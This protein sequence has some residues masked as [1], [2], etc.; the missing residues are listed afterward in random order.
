MINSTI[1]STRLQGASLLLAWLWCGVF[2]SGVFQLTHSQII[3]LLV[4]AVVAIM[5]GSIFKERYTEEIQSTLM[6][7]FCCLLSLGTLLVYLHNGSNPLASSEIAISL[8]MGIMG[9]CC[10]SAVFGWLT[11]YARFKMDVVTLS[12]LLN[13]FTSACIY[14]LLRCIKDE[15]LIVALVIL[16][17]VSAVFHY[18]V[19]LNH[20]APNEINDKTRSLSNISF[21]FRKAFPNA[22]LLAAVFFSSGFF[23]RIA[24]NS[25]STE[26]I[27]APLGIIIVAITSLIFL[28]FLFS[29]KVGMLIIQYTSLVL[30]LC[31]EGL[32]MFQIEG[33]AFA[34]SMLFGALL[35]LI[36]FLAVAFSVDIAN[37]FGMRLEKVCGFFMGLSML[38]L[39]L[40]EILSGMVSAYITGSALSSIAAVVFVLIP[41]A[42]LILLLGQKAWI[43]YEYLP[44]KTEHSTDKVVIEEIE[45]Y[46]SRTMNMLSVGGKE[47]LEEETLDFSHAGDGAQWNDRIAELCKANGFSPRQSEIFSY[48]ARGRNADYIANQLVISTSTVR[49]HIANIYRKLNVHT[50]QQLLDLIFR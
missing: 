50:Q 14:Y 13:T 40:G 19:K 39:L 34:L 30:L 44:N 21:P 18:M 9:F 6:P 15:F 29:R 42:F 48:L 33:S 31:L 7:F 17:L 8:T 45:Q 38:S 37:T 11:I 26:G 23:Y 24:Q 43:A 2:G 35:T 3:Y 12:V 32:V 41:L 25:A 22:F 16:P 28:W 27:A 10:W 49:T 47:T 20:V 4:G 36:S 5:V 46:L 1:L